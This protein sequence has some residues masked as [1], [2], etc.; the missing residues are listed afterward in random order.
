MKAISA[1]RLAEAGRSPIVG[2]YQVCYRRVLLALGTLTGAA[3]LMGGNLSLRAEGS[4]PPA[5]QVWS[6]NRQVPVIEHRVR[7]HLNC[8]Y[9][10]L[11][12]P[13]SADVVVDA[14]GGVRHWSVSPVQCEVP[15]TLEEGRLK[16]SMLKSHHLVVTVN[17]TRLLLLADPPDDGAF[18]PDKPVLD[19]TA[20]PYQLEQSGARDATAILQKACD[21][22]GALASGGI[23]LLP[24]GLYKTTGIRLP[25]RVQL[26]LA[27]G[28][29]LQGSEVAQ[30]YPEYPETPGT[31]VTNS[32]IRVE[33]SEHVRLFGRG[34]L[35]AQ[36]HRLSGDAAS[37]DAPRLLTNCITVERSHC[38][39]V[40][41]IICKEATAVA[42]SFLQ[43]QDVA[44]RRVKVI[45]D[46]GSGDHVDGIR[47]AA[48]ERG[49]VEDCLVHTTADAFAVSAPAG[50]T[51]EQVVFRQLVAYTTA[52]ALRCG[53]QGAADM[54]RIRFEEVDVVHARDAVDVMHGEGEGNWSDIVFRDIRVE[55]CGRNSLAMHLLGGGSLRDVRFEDVYFAKV[56]PGFI[57]GFDPG[58]QVEDVV[59]AGLEMAGRCIVDGETAGIRVGPFAAEIRFED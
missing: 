38:V 25:S 57:S 8:T 33:G 31:T 6:N 27:G 46:V 43:C 36:G 15:V 56:R 44:V 5:I 12:L 35:D 32:L 20:P 52:R 48:V 9:A 21:D 19:V 23:V 17:G 42:V 40:E 59:F 49:L 47:L 55:D 16:F 58:H 11:S 4:R 39:S 3:V 13:G 29:V 2:R 10:P 50:T 18:P 37:R 30:D 24:P 45:N 41:G 53:P 28:A 14:P 26:C 51:T 34:T 7:G 54:K 1:G 22:A